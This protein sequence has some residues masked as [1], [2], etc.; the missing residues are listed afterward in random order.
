MEYKFF[1]TKKY[2]LKKEPKEKEYKRGAKKFADLIEQHI[3][4]S[5]QSF[6]KYKNR[7]E[8]INNCKHNKRQACSGYVCQNRLCIRSIFI[9]NKEIK[10]VYMAKEMSDHDYENMKKKLFNPFAKLELDFIEKKILN[11]ENSDN[12]L[13]FE[14]M[15]RKII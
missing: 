8:L 11:K 10:V 15:K 13:S 9:V 5:P 4:S 6:D 14:Q 2:K 7:L 3:E 1:V 12:I